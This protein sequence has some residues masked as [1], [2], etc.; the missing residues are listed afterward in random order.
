MWEVLQLVFG[1]LLTAMA[2]T[3]GMVYCAVKRQWIFVGLLVPFMLLSLALSPFARPIL[4]GIAAGI[5][6]GIMKRNWMLVGV[7]VIIFVVSWGI[8]MAMIFGR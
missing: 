8:G 5:T 4:L 2:I 7:C 3:V 1:S 6:Y